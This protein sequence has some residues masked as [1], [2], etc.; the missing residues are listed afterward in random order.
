MV[1]T[2]NHPR[3]EGLETSD[4]KSPVGGAS[5]KPLLPGCPSSPPVLSVCPVPSGT[6]GTTEESPFEDEPDASPEHR[7]D[8]LPVQLE[9][10][11]VTSHPV[12]PKQTLLFA[13]ELIWKESIVAKLDEAHRNELAD[14][15]RDCH[16]K[17]SVRQ[18]MSCKSH[19][20]FWNRC[21]VKWC[22]V[23]ASRLS[24]E[25]KESVQ[26]WTKQI[27]QPKHVVLTMRNTA[28]LQKS[29]VQRFKRCFSRLRRT[30]FARN[31]RGGFYSLECTNESRGWHL[32]LHALID[33]HWI[34]ASRLAIE[35]G[36]QLGQDFA[37][38]K[39][40]DC[41]QQDYLAEVT[42][43]AVKGSDLA[44]WSSHDMISFIEAFDGVKT[45]GVFGSLYAK[46]TEWKEFLDELRARR[47]RCECGCDRW[48]V[49]SDDEFEWHE[50]ID[51]SQSQSIPPPQRSYD[52]QIEF[53]I[54]LPF[55]LY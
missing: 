38:V 17:R 14:Q 6:D 47:V 36:K 22:P 44:G 51:D 15:I 2:L 29:D 7:F 55:N 40:K 37:I 18:C 34:D 28:S 5:S 50:T 21:E 35:W 48:R 27:S 19:S 11:G 20:M 25:R 23:C 16:L 13:R 31:W 41:R 8:R 49:M 54:A 46:R 12:R 4:L 52:P 24:R 45:F 1:K 42:K 39:V 9:T 3:W 53:N 10:R 30:T 26:W 32:H 43:Y 33:A